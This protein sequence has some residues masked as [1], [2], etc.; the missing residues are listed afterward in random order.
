MEVADGIQWSVK[1]QRKNGHPVLYTG[2][3]SYPSNWE[4]FESF[5]RLI[6]RHFPDFSKKVMY[7]QV[8]IPGFEKLYDYRFKGEI[9]VAEKVCVPFGLHDTLKVGKVI[10]K[11]EYYV[12]DV[13]YP[14]EKMKYIAGVLK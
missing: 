1:L 3:N 14:L 13:P 12:D 7:Y 4:T 9:A 11:K 8:E 2:S 6:Q 10:S 5:I